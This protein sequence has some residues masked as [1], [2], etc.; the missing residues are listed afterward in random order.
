MFGDREIPVLS[1]TSTDIKFRIP[2]DVTEGTYEVKVNRNDIVD[3]LWSN[4]LGLVISLSDITIRVCDNGTE[5]DDNFALDVNG[6]RVGQTHSTES[7]YCFTFPVTVPNGQNV[8]VLT[9]LD[10]PDSVG[11]YSI[12]FYGVDDVRGPKKSGS[13]LIPGSAAKVYYFDV[14][15]KP[16]TTKV[17]SLSVP[18]TTKEHK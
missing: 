11:T 1:A 10:A 9:G 12:N 13:D 4:S 18:S 5:K 14:S 16:Q 3:S 6:T 2:H 8:A 17:I 15:T 7:N